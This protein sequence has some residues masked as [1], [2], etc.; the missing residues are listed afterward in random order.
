MKVDVLKIEKGPSFIRREANSGPEENTDCC[1]Q[2]KVRLGWKAVVDRI[3]QIQSHKVCLTT[4]DRL[5]GQ[6]VLQSQTWS[7]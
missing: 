6:F 3:N 4:G 1:I 7:W 2:A 5:K